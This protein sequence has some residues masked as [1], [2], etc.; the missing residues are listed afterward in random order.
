LKGL[1]IRAPFF[2][3]V[4]RWV[5]IYQEWNMFAPFPKMDNVWVE[6]PGV[7]SDGSEID[8]LTGIRDIYSVK[9]QAFVK[10]IPN[11]HWRKFFLNLSERT[12][13]ARYYG[14]FLCRKWNDR[15]IKWVQ[16]TTLR[17][18]EIVVY[19]QMNLPNGERGGISRKLSWRHWCFDEDMRKD[20]E[21]KGL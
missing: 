18:M 19:S 2:Q 15:K 21:A 16:G 6:T 20:K 17:K 4:T 14:G 9:D 3:D 13:Y 8:V 7:L 10:S 11:E 1:R 5:H 12:D